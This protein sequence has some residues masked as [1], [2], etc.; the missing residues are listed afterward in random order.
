MLTDMPVKIKKIT[1]A[2]NT[3][4][5][6]VTF[7][8]ADFGSATTKTTLTDHAV[9]IAT[10]TITAAGHFTT[11]LIAIGDGIEIVHSDTGLSVGKYF[12][13]VRTSDDLITV[14]GMAAPTDDTDVIVTTKTY[15]QR[16]V[17]NLKS[18]GTEKQP[19][20]VDFG[21]GMWFPSLACSVISSSSDLVYVYIA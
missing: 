10:S 17:A 13:T 2:P 3:A 4:A 7:T 11:S 8:C 15:A 1:L 16:L 9:A 14:S 21:E 20:E 5:D 12:C 18:S 19:V 6:G